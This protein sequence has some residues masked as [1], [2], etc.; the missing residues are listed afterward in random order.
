MDIDCSV[1]ISNHCG[2]SMIVE[3][4]EDKKTGDL[5]LPIPD[6]IL[7]HINADIGDTLEFIDNEDGTF[8]IRKMDWRR[9]AQ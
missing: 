9:Y 5:V 3:I 7:K 8:T 4:E 1:N 2:I 6:E